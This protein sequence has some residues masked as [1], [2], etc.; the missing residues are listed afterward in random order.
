MDEIKDL[1]KIVTGNTKK[2]IPLL[3]LKN[4]HQ[5][6]NKEMNLFLGI[7]N[8]KFNNDEE[9]SSGI[10]G[11]EEVDFKFRMLKSRLS[12]KLLNHLFFV[13]FSTN[14]YSKST[15][16]YQEVLDYFHFSRML[17]NIGEMKLGTKLLQKTMD[18]AEEGEF[19]ALFTD[20]LRE[21][22]EIYAKTYRPKLF[23]NIKARI[24]RSEDLERKEEKADLIYQESML[25]IN[26]SVTN[27]KKS[28][29]PYEQAVG[30][31]HKLYK[32]TNSYNIFERYFKLKIRYHELA[33]DFEEVLNFTAQIEDAF[34]QG[35]INQRRFDHLFV[36]SARGNAFIKL[37]NFEE[38]SIFLEQML[39]ELDSS[40]NEW[41]QFA[42]KYVMLNIYNEQ[43]DSASEIFFRVA[44]NKTFGELEPKE[45]LKWNTIRAYLYYLSNQKKLIRKFDF[46]TFITKTPA[47]EKEVAGYNVSILIL[48][49]LYR[50]DGDLSILHAKLDAIDD[51]VVRFLNNSF[52]RRTKTFCKL[53]HKIAVH[54]KNRN[55]IV[56]K[57]KYLQD[58]LQEAEVAGEL[59]VDFETVPYEVL[60]NNVLE[61]LGSIEKK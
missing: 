10:Y 56:L 55:T 5:N 61:K 17:L 48:Q 43:Y 27:R 21:L 37:R 32:Q 47:F 34:K 39:T 38:G 51:Y 31:L 49:M 58:K 22:R 14:K 7:K 9:A 33:G 23:E 42:E 57:S 19:T 54:N 6:G 35:K 13:D 15:S 24:L 16:F 18:L 25:N 1:I 28:F 36:L 60:W 52:S 41:Y 40:S 4:Q 50:L 44:A 2:S 20:C 3:D 45:Q 8:G 26:S 11:S 30:E 59:F 12:R 53:L 46:D 29:E